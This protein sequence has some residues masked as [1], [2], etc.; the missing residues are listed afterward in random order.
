MIC[1]AQLS[2]FFKRPAQL[3]LHT[4]MKLS[5]FRHYGNSSCLDIVLDYG[6]TKKHLLLLQVYYNLLFAGKSDAH[7]RVTSNKVCE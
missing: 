1:I 2:Y 4:S 3:F 5:L 6:L 7:E